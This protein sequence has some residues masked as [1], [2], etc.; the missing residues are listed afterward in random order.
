M[1]IVCISDTHSKHYSLLEK[2]LITDDLENT[3]L[4]HAGD[5]STRGYR[6]QT[7][8]FLNWFSKL[9]HKYKIFI[10]GNHDFDF[11]DNADT[12]NEIIPDNV[13]YLND[14]LV[15]IEGI[16]IWGSPVTPYFYNW[17]FNRFRGANIKS[18]WDKIPDDIDILIT[19]GP[20][21]MI[22]DKV[23]Y[24]QKN[25]G[26]VDLLNRVQEIRPKFHIFGHIH[27]THGILTVDD[28]T[29]INASVLNEDYRLVNKPIHFDFK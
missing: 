28:V 20:P 4:I 24:D 16:K 19:H 29:F 1:K 26:C 11:E 2:D 23:V 17:A 12:I 14:S 7:I 9:P 15:E 25:V 3:I 22:L 21:Y 27:E 5:I 13:I 18:Y 8:D 10:A 6:S